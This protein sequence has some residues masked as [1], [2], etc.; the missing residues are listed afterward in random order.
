MPVTASRSQPTPG[1]CQSSRARAIAD[2]SASALALSKVKPVAVP[3]ARVSAV[4]S[5]TVSASPPVRWTIGTVP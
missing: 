3:A 5:T 1:W 4:A 2:Q